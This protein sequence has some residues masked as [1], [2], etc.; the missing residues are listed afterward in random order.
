MAASGIQEHNEARRKERV[1]MRAS[2]RD[3][4]VKA[5]IASGQMQ[6]LYSGHQ[7]ENNNNQGGYSS[8]ERE[9]QSRSQFR[10]VGSPPGIQGTGAQA[11]DRQRR[12]ELYNNQQQEYSA[13]IPHRFRNFDYKSQW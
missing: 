7:N 3:Q 11:V 13:K 2:K 10:V 8:Y 4:E 6:A 12:M 5:A 9:V 1:I